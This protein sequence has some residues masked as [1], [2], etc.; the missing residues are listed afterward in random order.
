MVQLSLSILA[1]L[2]CTIKSNIW[3]YPLM[4]TQ[5]FKAGISVVEL[6]QLDCSH[7]NPNPLHPIPPSKSDQHHLQES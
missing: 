7:P 6:L 2:Q 5:P 3:C 4:Q 1:E